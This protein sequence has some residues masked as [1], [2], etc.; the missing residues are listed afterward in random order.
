MGIVT[1]GILLPGEVRAQ[2][3]LSA[4]AD[5]GRAVGVLDVREFGAS[6]DGS[7]DDTAAIQKALD[8]AGESGGGTVYL[9]GGAYVIA[10][11]L[12]VPRNVCLLGGWQAP[13]T[14]HVPGVWRPAGSG[15][16]QSLGSTLLAVGG[17]GNPNG[18]ALIT[19]R[20]NATLRGLVVHYPKQTATDPPTAYPWTIRGSGNNCSVLD[21]MLVNPYQALNLDGAGRHYVRGLYGQPLYRGIYVDTCLDCG[22]IEDV[23]FWPFWERSEAVA[24]FVQEKGVAFTF[25]RTDQQMAA[26]CFCIRYHIGYHFIASPNAKRPGSAGILMDMCNADHCTYGYLVEK[27]TPLAG[28]RATNSHIGKLVVQQT[29][30]GIIELTNCKLYSASNDVMAVLDGTAQVSLMNCHFFNRDRDEVSGPMVQANR[31][32][33]TIVGCH[34]RRP[35]KTQIVLGPELASAVIVGNTLGGG[36][37]IVNHSKGDVQI[38]LNAKTPP[39]KT[40]SP[41]PWPPSRE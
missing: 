26:R 14:P 36:E 19:L 33:L 27:V 4:A 40:T 5:R 24:R 39:P 11:Q 35:D 3:S 7:R 37:R 38:G 30:A 1:T 28:L 34:F 31:G 9:P 20:S 23:H 10:G 29:N 13:P 8:A 16:V 41:P 22:R 15:G 12:V 32:Q 21:M 17:A 6:G 2:A 18:Q 25:G